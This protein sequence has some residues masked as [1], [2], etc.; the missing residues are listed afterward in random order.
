MDCQQI[1]LD[2]L[3]AGTQI[4]LRLRHTTA[5]NRTQASTPFNN[6]FLE[7]LRPDFPPVVGEVPPLPL[8]VDNGVYRRHPL[9]QFLDG[10][11][12]PAVDGVDGVPPSQPLL[13]PEEV[14]AVPILGLNH[15]HR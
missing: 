1:G 11:P 7:V 4:C 5:L 12:A 10:A 15:L 3:R 8:E 9:D 2:L 6:P 14:A 13:G